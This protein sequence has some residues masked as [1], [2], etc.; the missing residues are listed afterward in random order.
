[1]VLAHFIVSDDVERSD[2]LRETAEHRDGYEKTHPKHYCLSWYAPY[3]SAREQGS[4]PDD[5]SNAAA[6]YVEGAAHVVPR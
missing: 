2:L 6:L 5:V 4:T 1:M 3:A